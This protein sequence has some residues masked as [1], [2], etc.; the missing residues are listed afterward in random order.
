MLIAPDKFAGTLSAVEAAAAIAEGWRRTSPGDDLVEVPLAD[1]GPGFVAVLHATLGG[2][3]VPVR[4]TGPLGTPV[5]ASVLLVGDTAY[6]ETAQ[7]CGLHL[8]PAPRDPRVTTTYGVGEL[9]LA[10]RDA[11]DANAAA[12]RSRV[13]RLLGVS[14]PGERIDA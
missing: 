4:V 14:D 6:V 10:A 11:K 12:I 5:D 9:V 2:E 8:V 13:A 1:G 3:L 7:A